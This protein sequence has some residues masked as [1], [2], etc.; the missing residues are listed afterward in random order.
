MSD[1]NDHAAEAREF[2]AG[3]VTADDWATGIAM[4]HMKAAAAQAHAT[5][6]LVEQQRIANIIA[7]LQCK[8]TIADYGF[9]G[10]AEFIHDE[11]DGYPKAHL[12]PEIREALGI[13]E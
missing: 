3:D 8:S 11:A 6:A 2:L 1:R 4:L 10:L 7:L 13:R 12:R 5:L 9:D